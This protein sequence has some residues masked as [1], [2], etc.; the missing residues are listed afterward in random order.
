MK[1]S[2]MTLALVVVAMSAVAQDKLL[3]ISPENLEWRKDEP[4]LN[5]HD[6]EIARLLIP[7]TA[8]FGMI[9]T[10]SSFFPERVL[11][12]DSKTKKLFWMGAKSQI[13]KAMSQPFE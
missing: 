9:H 2:L 11:S 10:S 3:Y 4:K 8:T 5:F 7:E 13:W 12:Y 1:K 6:K